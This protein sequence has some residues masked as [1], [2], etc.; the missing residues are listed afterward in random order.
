MRPTAGRLRVGIAT[1]GRFHLLDLARELDALGVDVRFYSYVPRNRAGKFGLPAHCH[2]ALLPFVFPLIAFER[3]FPHLF[4]RTIERLMCWALDTAV[5]FRMRRCD[6]FVCMSGM[7]LNAPCFARRRYGAL[8]I[9]HRGS[10]HILS[11]RDILARLSKAWQVTPFVTRRELQGYAMADRIAVPSSHVAESFAPW[12]ELARK[13]FV[14]PYGVAL[15]QFPLRGGAPSRDPTV[16]YVGNW[17]Y[18]KGVDVLAE[19]I[20]GMEGVRL[21]HVGALVDAP[22]P[23]HSRFAHHDPVPQWEL[24]KFYQA[25]HMFALASRQDGL[26]MV[27]LQALAS[28]L[29][30]VC[31][32]R[33]GGTDLQR[34]PGLARLIRVVPPDD[35]LA[36]RCALTQAL[37]DATGETGVAPITDS[38]RE[39]LS[40]RGYA[41]RD[42]QQ[43][44]EMLRQSVR[45]APNCPRHSDKTVASRSPVTLE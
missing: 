9:L 33:T 1:A 28:G 31:T 38:E 26:A 14:N 5:M 19:A 7:Y 32:E 11:Q 45:P 12:A 30:V 44:N 2:V 29:L 25:A 18:Q 8:V 34:V 17:S 21:I 4:P 39:S 23:N 15:E 22:F 37:Q 43:M 6:V 41:L 24:T 13:L 16:L 10:K 20:A 36:L 3:L 35:V 42:L 27:I 40:W